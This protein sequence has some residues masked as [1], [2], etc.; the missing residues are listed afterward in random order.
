ML[1]SSTAIITPKHVAL[2]APDGGGR[3]EV[4]GDSIPE[5]PIDFLKNTVDFL[6]KLVG[7]HPSFSRHTDCL[8]VPRCK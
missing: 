1:R 4:S 8:Q 3:I 7:F 6:K 2:L 5:K